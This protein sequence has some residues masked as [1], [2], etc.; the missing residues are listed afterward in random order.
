MRDSNIGFRSIRVV[1]HLNQ[2]LRVG[3]ADASQKVFQVSEQGGSIGDHHIS[4]AQRL[5][6]PNTIVQ[7]EASV[8]QSSDSLLQAFS[9]RPVGTSQVLLRQTQLVIVGDKYKLAFHLL[10][11]HHVQ[12]AM[13]HFFRQTFAQMVYKSRYVSNHHTLG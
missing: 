2:D 7:F 1:V 4:G 10:G 8:V 12:E 11:G 5:G 13:P 3:D 9:A 6:E